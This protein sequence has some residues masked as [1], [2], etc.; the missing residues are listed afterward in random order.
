MAGVRQ[1]ERGYFRQH[2]GVSKHRVARHRRV[3]ENGARVDAGIDPSVLVA[4]GRCETKE[5][6][7]IEESI[8]KEVDIR[9]E[10]EYIRITQG[11]H[12]KDDTP[13]VLVHSQQLD[14][15]IDV[16]CRYK[17]ELGWL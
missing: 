3:P 7:L 2:A 1:P 5:M 6:P 12:L 14:W 8:L 16:L 9:R 17:R 10:G 11:F 4:G 13:T 15:L